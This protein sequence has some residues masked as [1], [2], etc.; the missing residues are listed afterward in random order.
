MFKTAGHIWLMWGAC[1][2]NTMTGTPLT[3]CGLGHAASA[4]AAEKV[5]AAACTCGCCDSVLLLAA[6]GLQQLESED[7]HDAASLAL[8]HMSEKHFRPFFPNIGGSV[9]MELLP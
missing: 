6:W 2:H 9:M 3:S 4:Q 1:A 5:G 8:V 7:L